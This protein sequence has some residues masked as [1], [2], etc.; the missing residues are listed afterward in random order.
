MRSTL[1]GAG[2][3][4][5]PALGVISVV[6]LTVALLTS[7]TSARCAAKVDPMVAVRYER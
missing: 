5:F 6:L 3:I 1:Y 4:D 2:T 7:Y